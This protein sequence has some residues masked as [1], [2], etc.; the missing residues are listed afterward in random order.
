VTQGE[1]LVKE[2]YEA[3]RSS[4]IWEKSLLIITYDEHGGFYDHVPPPVAVEPGDEPTSPFNNK[5]GFSFG[6]LGV[7]VPT[8]VVSPFAGEG[9]I[10]HRV[11]DHSS[12]PATIEDLFGLESLTRRD[13]QA[14]RV[15]GLL[16]LKNP[17]TDAP[18]TLPSPVASGV[19][20]EFLS[21]LEADIEGAAVE[22]GLEAERPVDPSL[23]G[24]VHVALLRE[25][26]TSASAERENKIAEARGVKSEVDAVR[27]IQKVRK[28]IPKEAVP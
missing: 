10:D 9:V 25:L 23:A 12:V 2:T 1:R 15:T 13:R 16:T 26:S 4:P 20:F 14:S 6:Q 28:S 21:R 5:H 17:R 22:M 27:Y 18:L 3:I 19:R 24:F 11:Y 8:V 7:R